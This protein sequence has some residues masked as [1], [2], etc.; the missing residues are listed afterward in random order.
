MKIAVYSIAFNESKHVK[1]WVKACAGADVLVV[2]DTGS[3]DG[4]QSLLRDAGVQV[5]DISIQPWRFD[6][7]RNTALNLVPNDVDIC[8]S[9]DLDEV[10]EAQFF[11][12]LR[13]QWKKGS[14]RG[15]IYMDTGT[16]WTSDRIH[17]RHGF[18]WKYPIHEVPAPSMGTEVVSCAID[19]TIRHSPDNSKSRAQYLTMLEQAVQEDP[20]QRMLVYLV[21]EYGF[22]KR[23]EDVIRVAYEVEEGWDVERS[24]AWRNAGD[25]CTHLGRTDQA[26]KFYESA[27]KTLPGEPEPWVALAQH[28][29]FQKNWQEC[30]DASLKG[31]QTLPVKHYL[32]QPTSMFQLSDFASLSAW[33]LGLKKQAITWANKAISI[34]RDQR[35]LEN[36]AFYKNNLE[37]A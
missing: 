7:A 10:P 16:V 32:A 21:R 22:H 13:K 8:V 29:Y 11:N 5:H 37:S 30:Y 26:L 20:D 36:L 9:V 12:K 1:R 31:L 25:A 28:H 4:T 24:A 19:A 23:W 3:T 34:T 2:A 18:Q 14:N 15:W 33:E 35:V 6:S 17:A 27:A